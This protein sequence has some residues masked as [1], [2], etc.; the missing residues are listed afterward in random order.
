MEVSRL[1]TD[2]TKVHKECCHGD[3]LECAD[4]RVKNSQYSLWYLHISVA[5]MNLFNIVVTAASEL[6]LSSMPN[7]LSPFPALWYFFG[8]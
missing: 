6:K 5:R 8:G 4:D 7:L 3:L 1:V 2:L